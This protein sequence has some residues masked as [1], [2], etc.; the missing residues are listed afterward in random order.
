MSSVVYKYPIAIGENVLCLPKGAE[1]ISVAEQHGGTFIW[2]VVDQMAVDVE[3]RTVHLVMTGHV[4]NFKVKQAIGTVLLNG[5]LFV[6]HALE[7]V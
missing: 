3:I 5:G 7:A 6:L 2:A 1:I 4:F